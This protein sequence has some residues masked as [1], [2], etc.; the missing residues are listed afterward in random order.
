MP[1]VSDAHRAAR[2]HEIA[3]AA[4]RCFARKG[5]AATSMSDIIAESGLSAGAIYGHYKSKD[6]L[7]TLAITEVL[8]L[9]LGEL[10]S[11]RE[12]TPMPAPGEI[13]RIVMSGMQGE[14][15]SLSIL[16]QIWAHAA[17]EPA[18]GATLAKVGD[19][20]KGIFHDYLRAWYL[21]E[22]KLPADDAE[23]AAQLYS[24]LYVGIV[25]GFI[26]Q[27]SIF[28]HFDSEAYLEAASSIL[29]VAGP[30]AAQLSPA[31]LSR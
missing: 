25:Q 7:I 29:P 10:E 30:G 31:D 18:V 2:R 22:L 6:E 14:L 26:V 21:K 28:T 23:R 24:G 17:V 12:Q 1:K 3:T 5:F 15:G 11:A 19:R 27:S 9:R 8:D 13:V 4:L 16:V 20:V